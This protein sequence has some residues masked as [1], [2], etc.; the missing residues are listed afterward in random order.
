ME[1]A[2][3]SYLDKYRLEEYDPEN[4]VFKQYIEDY[5]KLGDTNIYALKTDYED[6][7]D[8][9]DRL[10]SRFTVDRSLEDAKEFADSMVEFFGEENV[11]IFQ[12]EGTKEY[13]VRVA[14]PKKISKKYNCST[15]ITSKWWTRSIYSIRKKLLEIWQQECLIG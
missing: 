6:A 1:L 12:T 2:I 4:T 8:V 9:W 10:S 14:K 7:L 5:F 15:S 13:R 11:I 3:K